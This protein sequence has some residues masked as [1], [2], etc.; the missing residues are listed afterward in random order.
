MEKINFDVSLF[1]STTYYQKDFVEYIYTQFKRYNV[2]WRKNHIKINIVENNI[3]TD[4]NSTSVCLNTKDG[5]FYSF[6]GHN[7]IMNEWGC[8]KMKGREYSMIINSM[9]D[10]PNLHND[11]YGKMQ[12]V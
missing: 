11:Y 1:G 8:D 3:N 2:F 10:K 6:D 4:N 12:V 9:S 7:S 5:T